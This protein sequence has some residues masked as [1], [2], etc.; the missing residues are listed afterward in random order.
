MLFTLSETNQIQVM[1]PSFLVSALD[2]EY[3]VILDAAI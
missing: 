3:E 1:H 2:R